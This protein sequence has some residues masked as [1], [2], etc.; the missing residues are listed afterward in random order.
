SC[1]CRLLPGVDSNATELMQTRLHLRG[2]RSR[3]AQDHALADD[4]LGMTN[5]PALERLA[6]TERCLVYQADTVLLQ[7]RRDQEACRSRSEDVMETGGH[8]VQAA[9]ET[10]HFLDLIDPA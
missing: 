1:S 6:D 2:H 10:L 9:L 4:L 5:R 7:G 3:H 8:G